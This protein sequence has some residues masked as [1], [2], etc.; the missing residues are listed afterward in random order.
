MDHIFS[1]NHID[2]YRV[3]YHFKIMPLR[4][5][6]FYKMVWYLPIEPPPVQNNK[7]RPK[8][9]TRREENEK[10][11]N[12]LTQNLQEEGYKLHAPSASN[13]DTTKPVT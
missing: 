7:G 13:K 3:A 6:K 12:K 8:N 10:R 5:K 9:K 1:F 11:R 4:G 2:M